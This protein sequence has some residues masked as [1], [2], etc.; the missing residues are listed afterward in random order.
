MADLVG[1]AYVRVH[2]D[3]K[4][5]ERA[6]R[7][8]MS[9]IGKEGANSLIADFDKTLR[10]AATGRLRQSQ[11]I[12]ADAITGGDF[13]AMFRRS[14]RTL[15][16][17]V[18]DVGASLEEMA[19]HGKIKFRDFA[20]AAESLDDWAES[21]RLSQALDE[22]HQAAL[23]LN[24]SIDANAASA[25]KLQDRYERL[26]IRALS[27]DIRELSAEFEA[28]NDAWQRAIDNA[29]AAAIRF[30]EQGKA[31]KNLERT[32]GGLRKELARLDTDLTKISLAGGIGAIFGRGSRNNFLNFVGS[33]AR[34]MT[35]VAESVV[36]FPIRGLSMLVEGSGSLAD[37]FKAMR[38]AGASI[39]AIIGTG[40]AGA[41]AVGAPALIALAAA[42]GAL[43]VVLP[44]LAAAAS[45]AAGAITAIAGALTF[46]LA[47]SVLPLV[48]AVV[49]LGAG[50]AV[51]AAGIT[52]L[53]TNATAADKQ[54]MRPLVDTFNNLRKT[55]RPL[56]HEL[57]H[58]VG[59]WNRTFQEVIPFIREM[60]ETALT[61][62]GYF[63][64]GV[65]S[66]EMDQF[67]KDWGESLPQ[68]FEDLSAGVTHL[69][70]ALTAFFA[71]I[72][73]HAERLA[74]LFEDAMVTFDNWARSA[75]GQDSIASFMDRAWVAADRLW[76]AIGNITEAIGNIF[77]IGQDAAGG[78][79]LTWL[80]D[81]TQQFETF[82]S[83][84]EGKEQIR[85]WFADAREAGATFMRVVGE[86]GAA[87]DALDS[88]EGRQ[89]LKDFL[90]FAQ[91]VASSG[92]AV[93]GAI[94]HISS[95][96][97]ELGTNISAIK[98]GL[99]GF[100]AFLGEVFGNAMEDFQRH[101]E[102]LVAPFRWAWE[103]LFGNSYVPDIVNGLSEFLARVP[104]IITGALAGVGS[105]M[106]DPFGT[107]RSLIIGIL[108]LL[109]GDVGT[110]LSTAVSRARTALSGVPGALSG[111]FTSARTAIGGV[112]SATGADISSRAG[113]WASRARSAVSG[114]PGALS[115][116]FETAR[117]TIS[118]IMD[119]IA[120]FI[121]RIPGMRQAAET[122]RNLIRTILNATIDRFNRLPLPDI[123]RMMAGGVLTTPT[124]IH[125]GEA[126]REAIIPLD[127]PLSQID[128]SV[129]EMAAL[130]RGRTLP[131]QQGTGRSVTV[132]P[133]AI[134]V[135]SP[136]ADPRHVAMS[137]LD[138]LVALTT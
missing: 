112:L 126:G 101:G 120:G 82:T 116:A 107:A 76:G 49:A 97:S 121:A 70:R 44:A 111:Y 63:R 110:R 106:S 94:N 102:M 59:E 20:L 60:G 66:P 87:F 2:A 45:L 52:E 131:A 91:W 4:F 27:H 35:L 40:L 22:A 51:V 19:R 24:Q 133:G 113:G 73:P 95:D 12:L 30:E 8:D 127:R 77:D 135:V 72:L 92:A 129:R 56:I 43:V 125:A 118:G 34:N 17:F 6:I 83:S 3:T 36:R 122:G 108:N 41:V 134:T 7:R 14:R 18:D 84:P 105:L 15:D 130:L 100:V 42:A 10:A 78:S 50:I 109:P 114:I 53:S 9:K 39:P 16:E 86:L 67:F 68:I 5:M 138:Q 33:V 104:G 25:E 99:E 61:A 93:A 26:E 64:S 54:A 32:F 47:G 21:T 69:F 37:K 117:R 28:S 31:T 58:E 55:A 96:F 103:Q 1:E 90:E 62:F 13:T 115:G 71:P 79:F 137:A 80:E 89:M 123:P 124:T 75:D 81:V 48:P 98:G 57:A 74:S 11:Q 38:A 85:Q 23:R 136:Y 65:Q 88:P 29:H 119:E 128:P 46:A 132:A